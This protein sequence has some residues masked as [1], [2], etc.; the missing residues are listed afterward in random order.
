MIEKQKSLETEITIKSLVEQN[1]GKIIDC[2]RYLMP[3]GIT[4]FYK[5]DATWRSGIDGIAY[6]WLVSSEPIA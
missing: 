5:L 2:S 3:D 4:R 1:G 6:R